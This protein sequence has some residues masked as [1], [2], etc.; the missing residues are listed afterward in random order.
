MFSALPQT[1][2]NELSQLATRYGQPLVRTVELN[3]DRLFDPL[4]KNDRYG[5]VCMVVQRP[6]GHLLTMTKTFYPAGAYRLPTGG[7][8]HGE[9]VLAALLRE[10]QEETGLAVNVERFLAAVAYRVAQSHPRPVFYTF[11]F[12]LKET[13]GTLGSTDADERV[14]G[15]REIWPDQLPDLATSL[16]HADHHYSEEIRGRWQSWGEFRAVIH[17]LVWE[18]LQ[19]RA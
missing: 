6:D 10:T 1:V 14:A 3:V 7:I 8:Q 18:A 17:S 19:Q 16:A 4:D 11:A 15:F 12:L 13:G 9:P 2:Q 5:E